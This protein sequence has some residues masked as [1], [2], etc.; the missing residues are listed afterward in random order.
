[1]RKYSSISKGSGE[2]T[3]DGAYRSMSVTSSKNALCSEIMDVIK[4][5]GNESFSS[6]DDMTVNDTWI[7]ILNFSSHVPGWWVKAM[8]DDTLLTDKKLVSL[9]GRKPKDSC[10]S[11]VVFTKNQEEILRKLT[12]IRVDRMF[13][14]LGATD[15]Q[16]SPSK[17]ESNGEK[18]IL[19]TGW[20]M[21]RMHAI[22]MLPECGMKKVWIQ[23]FD[24]HSQNVY[25]KERSLL[26]KENA[27]FKFME[28]DVEVIN[29]LPEKKWQ[30]LLGE[31][32][33]FAH[34]YSVGVPFTILECIATH[35]PIL[36]NPLP[37]I[38]EYLGD[39]YPLYYY[40]YNEASH[41]AKDSRL[42]FDAHEYLR[43]LSKKMELQAEYFEDKIHEIYEVS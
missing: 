40:F 34:Y 41:M 17:F 25:Q 36:V 2:G 20:W 10:A 5:I 12:D 1:V 19:Q 31:N 24:S 32:I 42:L 9:I 13:Y 21:Q 39:D 18:K 38:R 27:F 26:T 11:L 3:K 30:K 8:P 15:V 33:V 22:Y 29:T 7:G 43:N 23:R 14:P 28:R 6:I 37:S 4:T 35:T 16:W